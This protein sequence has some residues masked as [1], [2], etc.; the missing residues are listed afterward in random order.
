M[1]FPKTI[2]LVPSLIIFSLT[3]LLV[4]SNI[5]YVPRNV[6]NY[7]TMDRIFFVIVNVTFWYSTAF[8]LSA[9]MNKF[10]WGGIKKIAVGD[11]FL[12]KVRDFVS[13]FLY[14]AA[15]V[16]IIVGVFNFEFTFNLFSISV[17]ILFLG[18]FIRS[19]ILA[20]FKSVFLGNSQ[21][22]NIGDWIKLI[23]TKTNIEIVGE[24]ED[25]DRKMLKL[26]TEGNNIIIVPQASLSEFVIQNYWGSGKQSRFE[27]RISIDTAIPVTRVKRILNAGVKD[28]I[29]RNGFLSEEQPQVLIKKINEC[30]TEFSV[31]FWI[32]PWEKFTPQIAKDKVMQSLLKHL[33]VSGINLRNK[34]ADDMNE[35]FKSK[36]NIKNILSNIELFANLNENELLLLSNKLELKEFVEGNKIITQGEEGSSMFVLVEGL[37]KA[38]IV[39]DNGS[40]IEVGQLSPGEFFGEMT[41]FTGE[42]RTA[43]IEC[44]CDSLVYEIKKEDLAPIIENRK[45]IINE[46]G[47]TILNRKD[48]NYLKKE[49]FEKPKASRLHQLINKIKNIFSK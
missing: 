36:M 19:N 43:T 35:K 11:F 17:I 41:L 25:V 14:L 33:N 26:K 20:F 3:L 13:M 31:F 12:H 8:L 44:E 49:E 24:V 27:V 1:K 38:S 45:E 15:T 2:N 40:E 23:G 48:I 21:N 46:F 39:A 34:K 4:L 9:I 22:F 16:I 42:K 6:S 32:E 30:G 28:A 29:R 18:T 7:Y 10:F 47:E 37:L 5:F